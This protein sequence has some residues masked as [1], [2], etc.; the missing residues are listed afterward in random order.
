MNKSSNNFILTF[1]IVAFFSTAL[2]NISFRKKNKMV[3]KIIF[4][5]VLHI[6]LIHT[7]NLNGRI[8]FL[9][10]TMKQSSLCFEHIYM[11]NNTIIFFTSSVWTFK[12]L[13]HFI[14]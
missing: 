7:A 12:T 1:F 11:A 3:M 5:F 8:I 10:K 9:G 14:P 13:T 6:T 4:Y 2:S